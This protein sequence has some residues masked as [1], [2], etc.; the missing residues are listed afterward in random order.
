MTKSNI[1]SY[2]VLVNGVE[3]KPLN[4]VSECPRVPSGDCK[5]RKC[6]ERR[7]MIGHHKN[8]GAINFEKLE[9]FKPDSIEGN[10]NRVFKSVTNLLQFTKKHSCPKIEAEKYDEEN[11]GKTLHS[12][13]K[14]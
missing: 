8:N 2:M 5:K 10:K 6:F 9:V 3:K 7:L 14:P 1:G 4:E 13:E 11:A 12:C